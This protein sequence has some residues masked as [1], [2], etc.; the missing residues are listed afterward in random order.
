MNAQQR[1]LLD[2]VHRTLIT[3]LEA[4]L[5]TYD[6]HP[7]CWQASPQGARLQEQITDLEQAC[8]FVEKLLTDPSS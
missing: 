5:T 6:D 4:F 2:A 3:L 1:A 7:D 8:H